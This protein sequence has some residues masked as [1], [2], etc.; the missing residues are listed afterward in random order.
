MSKEH[1]LEVVGHLVHEGDRQRRLADTTHAQHAHH[2][3]AL[4]HHPLRKEGQF[5]LAS[6]EAR[7]I[8][9]FLPLHPPTRS[10]PGPRQVAWSGPLDRSRGYVG[11]RRPSVQQGGEPRLIKEHLLM[12]RSPQCAD[13]LFLAPGHKGLL[14]HPSAMKYLRL[15]ALG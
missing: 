5:R 10:K 4:P 3:A 6:I 11:E 14:L 9:H 2:P 15:S 13:L 1:D 12:R 7:H 8:L